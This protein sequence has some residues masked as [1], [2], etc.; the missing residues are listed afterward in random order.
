MSIPVD[1]SD[2]ARTLEG[3]GPGYLLS[4][5]GESV[6]AVSAEPVLRD[7]EVVVAGP[8]GGSLRNVAA[9]ATVT[10]L[11]PPREEHGYTLLVDGTGTVDGGDVRVR[12]G[13]A[14]LHRPADHAGPDHAGSDH[15]TGGTSACGHDCHPVT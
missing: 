6:K 8:G 2:L 13:H 14:V 12:P 10:L 5:A 3:Y 11:F 1:L 4:T 9:N 15:A 7:G